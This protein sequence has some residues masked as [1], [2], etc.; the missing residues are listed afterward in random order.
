[1]AGRGAPFPAGPGCARR[2]LRASEPRRLLP[3]AA[4]PAG[5]GRAGPS[6]PGPR[7][8]RAALGDRQRKSARRRR[9]RRLRRGQGLP[10]PWGA[11]DLRGPAPR[12]FSPGVRRTPGRGSLGCPRARQKQRCTPDGEGPI[13]PTPSRLE[14][15]VPESFSAAFFFPFFFL[16]RNCVPRNSDLRGKCRAQLVAATG[17]GLHPRKDQS[18]EVVIAT[19]A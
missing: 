1:M 15:E 12:G 14:S 16:A 2:H 7:P 18:L 9:R 10:R 3:P 5:P 8:S 17:T 19:Q 13:A 4:W 6:S 11:S